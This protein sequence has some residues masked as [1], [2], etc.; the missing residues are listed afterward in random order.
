MF[1]WKKINTYGRM[2]V[3][4]Q[5]YYN[6]YYYTFL[7]NLTTTLSNNHNNIL[8]KKIDIMY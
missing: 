2:H 6:P 1:A 3:R 7:F 5:T 8:C 4:C